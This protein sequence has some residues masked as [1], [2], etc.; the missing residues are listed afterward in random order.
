MY[1]FSNNTSNNF[2]PVDMKLFSVFK[3][4]L[5]GLLYYCDLIYHSRNKFS[6]STTVKNNMDYFKLN[7]IKPTKVLGSKPKREKWCKYAPTIMVLLQTGKYVIK[8]MTA[9]YIHQNMDHASYKKI[10]EIEYLESVKRL[11]NCIPHMTVPWPIC[12]VFKSTCLIY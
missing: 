4:T 5:V 10:Q 8:T 12:L 7:V 6:C 1:W 2:S 11:P 3:S 9:M